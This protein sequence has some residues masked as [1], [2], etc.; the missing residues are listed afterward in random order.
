MRRRLLD[1]FCGAGGAA[2]GYHRAGFDIVGVDNQPQ[3]RYPFTFLKADALD[4]LRWPY[5]YRAGFVHFD[6]IHASPPCQAFTAYRRNN[7][8]G[9]YP[10][11]IAPVRDLLDVTGLPYIIENVAGAPLHDPVLICGSMFDPAMDVRRHRLFE[12][13]WPLEPPMWPCRHKLQAVKRFPGGRSKEQGGSN[14]HHARMTI[15]VGTWDIPFAAQQEAMGIDWTTL[16]ELSEAIP[17][18]YTELIG[19]QLLVHLEA[20]IPA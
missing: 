11:L 5:H 15:E 6:A 14:R 10:D 1:L 4:V 12:T 8:V 19:D 2:M 3:P 9:D 17:P 20:K 18:A 7:N 13:N 16:E